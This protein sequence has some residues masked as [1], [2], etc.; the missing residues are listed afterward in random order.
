MKYRQFYCTPARRSARSQM[1]RGTS[2]DP[3]LYT[4]FLTVVLLRFELELHHS[5]LLVEEPLSESVGLTQRVPPLIAEPVH[6]VVLSRAGVGIGCVDGKL[7][8]LR[9]RW[10]ERGLNLVMPV[11]LCL[12]RK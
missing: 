5:P 7:R 1:K 10:D 6:L 4:I 8:S 9:K 3:D 12:V 2:Q 11:F